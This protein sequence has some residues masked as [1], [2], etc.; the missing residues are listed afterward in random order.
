LEN[1]C[2]NEIWL[3]LCSLGFVQDKRNG[4]FEGKKVRHLVTYR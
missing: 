2:N 1:L 3:I 4:N